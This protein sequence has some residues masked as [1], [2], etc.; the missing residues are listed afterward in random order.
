MERI[1]DIRNDFV[2]KISSWYVK[3]FDGIAVEGLDVKG[4]VEGK[5]GKTLHRNIMDSAWGKFFIMLSYKAERAGR[6]L[7]RVSPNGTTKRCSRCESVVFKRPWD[8]VHRCSF[9][10][11]D[12]QRDLNSAL[13]I[14]KFAGWG[15]PEEPVERRAIP[16]EVVLNGQLNSLKQEAP[17]VSWE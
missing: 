17:S 9:C 8:R 10:G 5:K 13:N 11:L 14:W 1:K 6:R 16:V 3:G 7:I 4:L 2:H 15:P 12:L